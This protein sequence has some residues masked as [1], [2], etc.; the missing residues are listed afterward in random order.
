MPYSD[1]E[2]RRAYGREWMRRNPEKAREAMRRWRQRHPDAHRA[3]LRA[4]Y[5]RSDAR[6]AALAACQRANPQVRRTAW[7]RRRARLLNANGTYTTREW[8]E[9]VARYRG[10]CAYCGS[11]RPL[12][13]DHR[14][15]LSRGGGNSI[16]NILPACQPCN[17][18]KGTGTER[19]FRIRLA[20]ESL[21]GTG[22]KVID[23]RYDARRGW[24]NSLS[25]GRVKSVTSDI[26]AR[27]HAEKSPRSR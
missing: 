8:L 23:W 2:N 20:S 5:L 4:Y 9:L 25:R 16:S 3:E 18:R 24:V 6:K 12:H 19:E 7:E 1:P 21:H 17:Q 11:R 22:F 10:R 14:A 13:A 26:R 27:I 15:P